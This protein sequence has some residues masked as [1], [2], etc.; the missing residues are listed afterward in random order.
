VSQALVFARLGL[1]AAGG[2]AMSAGA[3]RIKE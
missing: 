3:D 2:Y 1:S